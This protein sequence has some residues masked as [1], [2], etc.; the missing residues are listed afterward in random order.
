MLSG[1]GARGLT[2]IG[3]LKVLHEMRVPIDYIAGT[4]MGAIVGGLYASGMTPPRCNGTLGAVNWPTLLSDSPERRDV[5]FRRKEER[6]VSARR[7]RSAI[8]TA[9]SCWFKGALSG[10][11]L[12]L[13]LHELTRN[14]DNVESFD[15]LPIPYRAVATNMVTGKE[16]VFASGRLYQAMRASMSVPGMFAP[17][18][19][20]GR[21]LGDGGLVNNL[22]VD[23]VRA[24][25]ADIVIAV[26]IGTPLMSRDQ[27]Q[28]VV[29]Y[30]SQMLNILTEQNVRAQLAMLKPTDILISPDLGDLKFIDFAAAPKFVELGMKAA[31]AMRTAACR[32]DRTRRS[33][34]PR[35]SGDSRS[36]PER[37]RRSSTS[38]RSKVRA[39]R[40]RRCSR[41]RCGPSP[42]SRSISRR[43][44][45]ISPA[46]TAAASSS[47]ST[48][49]SPPS[50]TRPA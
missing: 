29:G 27:L 31:E 40:I 39:T 44:S 10:S 41:T 18:E 17:V 13:F 20:D 12:E 9:S 21:I 15:K 35:S 37:C 43:S 6:A 19:I 36:R 1:G 49:S 2:H 42:T 8:A 16:V 46:C 5:G 3:V 23:I 38:S 33:S 32:A 45:P 30:A 4:S 25:G 24:M 50:A 34:T 48:T 22:P 14:V 47:R 26:N 11:N 7:S 28:S